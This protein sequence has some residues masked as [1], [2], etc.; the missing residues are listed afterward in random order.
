MNE[1]RSINMVNGSIYD[2]PEYSTTTRFLG[3]RV[4]A[5]G[6]KVEF[7]DGRK[8]VMCSTAVNVLAGQLVSTPTVLATIITNK[9]TAASIGATSI[10]LDTRTFA[11]FGGAAG[12]IAANALAGGYITFADDLAEG[13]QYRIKSN[14]AGTA[15]SSITLTLFDGLKTAIDATTDVFLVSPRYEN[16]V[17]STATLPVVGVATITTTAATNARTEYF[18][19]QTAGIANTYITTGTNI[20]IGL[21]VAADTAGI[22]V[23]GAVTDITIGVAMATSTTATQKIPVLLNIGG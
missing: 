9:L 2:G 18:W 13:Y 4:P 19:V 21:T 7:D 22:K 20:A 12:V 23:A 5:V 16:V 17:L 8:Y 1:N 3:S 11:M 6:T 10:V 14:T 15:S